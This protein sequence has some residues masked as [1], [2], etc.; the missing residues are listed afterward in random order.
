[1]GIALV[2][3]LCRH[4]RSRST[5]WRPLHCLR[6][7][8]AGVCQT[9][10]ASTAFWRS[11][12]YQ[13]CATTDRRERLSCLFVLNC[14]I[15]DFMGSLGWKLDEWVGATR[16]LPSL[17]T[18]TIVARSRSR[19]SIHQ[20]QMLSVILGRRSQVA[21]MGK[22]SRR[23]IGSRGAFAAPTGRA[24]AGRDSKIRGNVTALKSEPMPPK[25][26][27]GQNAW[28]FGGVSPALVGAIWGHFKAS[29]L[30]SRLPWNKASGS[31]LGRDRSR[32]P[33]RP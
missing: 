3:G 13:N 26:S 6:A 25:D 14:L 7:P 28:V 29:H 32:L 10:S 1:M 2:P 12:R 5:A 24:P 18:G 20:R 11:K 33:P 30:I 15:D 17:P 19:C 16:Y 9:A 22:L 31:C 8:C 27:A 21:A 4:P 23:G